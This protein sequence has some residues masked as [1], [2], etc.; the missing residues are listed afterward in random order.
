[1]RQSQNEVKKVLRHSLMRIHNLRCSPR[2]YSRQ[3]AR[4]NQSIMTSCTILT[5]HVS[6]VTISKVASNIATLLSWRRHYIGDM[7]AGTLYKS[8]LKGWCASS[9]TSAIA[10]QATH[11]VGTRVVCGESAPTLGKDQ[12]ERLKW[13]L[14]TRG[15]TTARYAAQSAQVSAG[16]RVLLRP[17]GVI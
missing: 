1:M 5:C 2:P 11:K 17:E 14:N 10:V 4:R 8:K 7:M 3:N 9:Y 12:G 13:R 6:A 16:R 15:P